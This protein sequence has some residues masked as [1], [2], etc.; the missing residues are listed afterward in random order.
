MIINRVTFTGADNNTDINALVELQ[1]EFSFVEWGILIATNSGKKRYPTEEF[2][3]ELKDKNLN[4][5]LHLCGKHTRNILSDGIIDIKYDF[6]NRY[7]VNFNFLHT[8]HDLNNYKKLTE[9]F[10]D[11]KFIL[12]YNASNDAYIKK[13]ISEYNTSN[14][15]ILYDASGGRGT[16]IKTIK[17]P[18]E[19]IYTGYSGGLNPT[20]IVEICDEIYNHKDESKVWIDM[21]SG[22]RTE[23]EFDLDKVYKVLQQVDKFINKGFTI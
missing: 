4:L 10:P 22:V 2:I 17:A 9:S 23:D 20:N 3:L 6:F 13:I 5:A 14:T 15:N 16:E 7:Q 12:Q 18:Y 19:S 8:T 1:K 11:K 21:E